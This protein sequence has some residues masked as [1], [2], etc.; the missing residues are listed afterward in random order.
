VWTGEAPGQID[1][2][3]VASLLAQSLKAPG[4]CS[5]GIKRKR[6]DKMKWAWWQANTKKGRHST[7]S[8]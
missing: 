8:E 6:K 1:S 3:G 4:D 2:C 7:E 5:Y